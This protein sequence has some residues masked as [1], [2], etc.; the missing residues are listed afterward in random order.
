MTSSSIGSDVAARAAQFA[1]AQPRASA[2]NLNAVQAARSDLVRRLIGDASAFAMPR[3]PWA[4]LIGIGL[5]AHAWAMIGGAV[6]LFAWLPHPLTALLAV[7]LIG[8]RQLGLA[9][10]MHDGAH[11]ALARPARF[12]DWLSDWFCALPLLFATAPYRR[13]H[14]K[15]HAFTQQ[16]NDPDLSL[17][18]P[19]PITWKSL[20]RKVWRDLSGQTGLKQRAQQFLGAWRGEGGLGFVGS[21]KH[22]LATLGPG[23]VAQA[24]LLAVCALVFHWAYYFAFW[25]LPLL[26]WNMLVTRIRNIA[27]HAMVPNDDDPLRNARTTKASW[28]E[29]IFL[30]PYWVNYHLEHHLLMHVPCYRLPRLHKKLAAAG[31]TR[32][33]ELAGGYWAVL[34]KACTP[35]PHPPVG[36]DLSAA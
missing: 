22:F 11:R 18:A 35:P 2:G 27:E 23:L 16:D 10:L 29:R 36:A 19:F 33:M 8:S 3:N 20:G 1:A 32:D 24:V 5:V 9:I 30:A 26:T 25:L 31:V 14:L 7:M 28:W 13:Y 4:S 21:L 34:R 15:H 12:N 6:A 17:S